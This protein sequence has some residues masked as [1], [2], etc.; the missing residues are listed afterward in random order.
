MYR[1]ILEQKERVSKNREL[2]YN[3]IAILVALLLSGIVLAFYGFNPFTS[4]GG[5]FKTTFGSA[6]GFSDTIIKTI[7]LIFTGLSVAIAL[8]SKVWNVGAEGQLYIGALFA[9]CFALYLPT[10]PRIVEI[11]LI[12]LASM[13]G[14]ALWAFFP[15][16]LKMKF[17][18]NEVISTLLLNYV[19]ISIV[20]YF[21]YGPMKRQ[22]NFPY[23]EDIPQEAMFSKIGF[24][25]VHIGIIIALLL[26][27][28]LYYVL[29]H[30]RFGYEL[31]II[32]SSI[33]AA[34]YA[35]INYDRMMLFV[36]LLSG[37]FAGLAGA[38]QISGIEHKLHSHISSD[39]G[40]TGIIVA[41]LARS[42]PFIIVAFAFF[43]SSLIIG[44]EAL[45]FEG[46]P[47]A[48]GKVMQSL[49]LFCILGSEL[50]KNYKI[51]VKRG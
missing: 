28:I 23:S 41:W 18:M 4:I 40:Y 7:P 24:Q 44:S 35:G 19:A 36:F 9:T 27:V 43:M 45:E 37:A 5:M 6:F 31:R 39:L 50:F 49:I 12:L 51:K 3:L 1:V 46:V 22:D 2:L 38:N 34:N 42:N 32:G 25:N 13:I 26:V 16:F 33:K 21:V 17:K 14:G 10:F 15:A 20:E 30:T 29:K 8:N 11:P 48:I 47:V